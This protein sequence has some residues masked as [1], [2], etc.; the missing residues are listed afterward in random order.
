MKRAVRLGIGLLLPAALV[1][2]AILLVPPSAGHLLGISVRSWCLFAC[3]P[4]T[5]L[6]LGLCLTKDEREL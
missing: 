3:A 2:G 6:L 4:I 5:T 1:M